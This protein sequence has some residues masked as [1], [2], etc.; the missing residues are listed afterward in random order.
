MKKSDFGLKSDILFAVAVPT[1]TLKY[2]NW[3]IDMKF[4]I[5]GMYSSAFII[6]WA[7][8]SKAGTITFSVGM[9]GFILY[10]N[11]QSAYSFTNGSSEYVLI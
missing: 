8:K 6:N 5:I 1:L 4:L 3:N 10:F 9:A 11:I 2:D 7:L